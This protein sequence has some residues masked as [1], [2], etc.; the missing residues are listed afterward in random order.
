MNYSELLAAL[1]QR[2]QLPKAE[3]EKDWMRRLQ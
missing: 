3:V 1:A 2:L